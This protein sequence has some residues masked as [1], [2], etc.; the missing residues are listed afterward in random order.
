MDSEEIGVVNRLVASVESIAYSFRRIATAFEEIA[1]VV[2]DQA[3]SE[4]C[5]TDD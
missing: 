1:N 3:D 4:E 5:D 2:I